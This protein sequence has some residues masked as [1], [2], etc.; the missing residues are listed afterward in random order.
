VFTISQ[1]AS[2]VKKSAG[3]V[4]QM[5][6]QGSYESIRTYKEWFDIA[7]KAYQDQLNAEL[8]DTNIA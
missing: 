8:A 6:Q 4:Y 3:K 2:V 7:L 5:M 1:I